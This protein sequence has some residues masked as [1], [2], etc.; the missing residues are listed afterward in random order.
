ME[1]KKIYKGIRYS[2]KPKK[3]KRKSNNSAFIR[4]LEILIIIETP[5]LNQ[6]IKLDNSNHNL[7]Y[8]IVTTYT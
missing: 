8:N 1:D 3:K 4:F 5:F 6:I 7:D 2:I